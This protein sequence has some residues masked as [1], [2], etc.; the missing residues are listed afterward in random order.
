MSAHLFETRVTDWRQFFYLAT[1]LHLALTPCAVAEDAAPMR[2][3]VTEIGRYDANQFT[4]GN[5]A[6]LQHVG[7]MPDGRRAFGQLHERLPDGMYSKLMPV[8]IWD[9]MTGEEQARLVDPGVEL[10]SLV[11][12]PS[13]RYLAGAANGTGVIVWDLEV[14][15]VA[16]TRLV[17]G[18]YVGFIDDDTLVVA[19]GQ[20]KVMRWKSTEAPVPIPGTEKL[21]SFD[22]SRDGS[23][24]IATVGQFND[25]VRVLVDTRAAKRLREFADWGNARNVQISPDGRTAL[26]TF[27]N[28][29]LAWYDLETGKQRQLVRHPGFSNE[30]GAEFVYFDPSSR[31]ALWCFQAST[32]IVSVIELESGKERLRIV[33]PVPGAEYN[34]A[35]SAD[36][37]LLLFGSQKLSLF[38]MSYE[39]AE[40]LGIVGGGETFPD[41]DWVDAL[42]RKEQESL[43]PGKSLSVSASVLSANIAQEHE[44]D[45]ARL[46]WSELKDGETPVIARI[47]LLT[48]K[49]TDEA[50]PAS[51]PRFGLTIENAISSMTID[52]EAIGAGS[53]STLSLPNMPLLLRELVRQSLLVAARDE[54]GLSTWDES[55]DGTDSNSARS[56]EIAVL[57]NVTA[58]EI[59]VRLVDLSRDGSQLWEER[60]ATPSDAADQETNPA[61]TAERAVMRYRVLLERAERW[62]RLV[63][64]KVLRA[65]GY[66][67]NQRPR[68]TAAKVPASAIT[69]VRS[70]ELTTTF[71]ALRELHSLAL[72]SSRSPAVSANL[73]HGYSNLGL[74][75]ESHWSAFHKSC[76]ARALLYAQR[77]IAG[78]PSD[79]RL[80]AARA[81]AWAL[82]GIHS[83]AL[84]DASR[85]R[86]AYEG[87]IGAAPPGWL[88]VIE[89]HCRWDRATLSA[90]AANDPHRR[91]AS[92]LLFQELDEPL[93][94]LAASRLG[95]EILRD[96][97]ACFRV[98][99]GLCNVRPL[100]VRRLAAEAGP[101]ALDGQLRA[102]LPEWSIAIDELKR[103][104][105]ANDET[106]VEVG[107]VIRLLRLRSEF[108]PGEPGWSAM[109]TMLSDLQF[110]QAL[111]YIEL[112]KNA[113]AAPIG[114][115][116]AAVRKEID[117]HPLMPVIAGELQ[118][119]GLSQS[120]VLPQGPG[121]AAL[122]MSPLLSKALAELSPAHRASLRTYYRQ[123]PSPVVS[124]GF[125]A[126]LDNSCDMITGDLLAFTRS[127][128]SGSEVD[129]MILRVSPRCPVAFARF[130]RRADASAIA[131][132]LRDLETSHSESAVMQRA[133]ADRYALAKDAESQER[134]LRRYV[135]LSQE[136]IA[137]Q[138]LAG[139][140][141]KQGQLEQWRQTLDEFLKTEEYGLEHTYA[142]AE[143]ANHLM[144]QG[145]F[146]QAL[147]FVERALE[148]YAEIGMVAAIRCYSGLDRW[149]DAA[150]W[151]ER[152]VE[153]YQGCERDYFLWC[154]KYGRRP[155]REIY[156]ALRPA[157]LKAR[158]DQEPEM[159]F[160]SALQC[161]AGGDDEEGLQFF[162]DAV[163][164]LEDPHFVAYNGFHAAVLADRL[165]Q[166]ETRIEMLERISRIDAVSEAP[167][168]QAASA[169]IQWLADGAKPDGIEQAIESALQGAPPR[170]QC[171]VRFFTGAIL[172]QHGHQNLANGLFHRAAGVKTDDGSLFRNS[173]LAEAELYRQNIKP[174]SPATETG[175]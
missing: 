66:P 138:D 162:S 166:P 155:P 44:N 167:Y 74:M 80:Q 12:S 62:S 11:V 25:N 69:G 148:S 70:F 122:P 65:A 123:R 23:L 38:H 96:N 106:P 5:F 102:V 137:F 68:T 112:H 21:L 14:G 50:A 101:P 98:L 134:C 169:L 126:G 124:R 55:L 154:Q 39:F 146:T 168:A 113:L 28:G 42:V 43:E 48:S 57:A 161:V 34:G 85:A 121:T 88:A 87:R 49:P 72:R 170:E 132:P 107:Q 56:H 175:P 53:I 140:Y 93:S 118:L 64:P 129:T 86:S 51:S 109:G 7:I 22:V 19:D 90:V 30:N 144:D 92:M 77:M 152:R 13:G 52:E 150:Q 83:E 127:V 117:G 1:A 6:V 58:E 10:G 27:A 47:A 103:L 45:A 15:K 31:F 99:D 24:A 8:V 61:V 46:R 120:V 76:H 139:F 97:P 94:S 145:D 3:E 133:L 172:Q 125:V 163:A 32:A 151:Y 75:T 108:H 131:A 142:R 104:V 37:S 164:R 156:D 9:A 40:E 160:L 67:D 4:G 63:F 73:V 71:S 78:A 79:A 91:L 81:Y 95:I 149:D 111:R 171:N 158:E 115:L 59:H 110:I 116:Q 33:A 173:E 26:A 105:P 174:K 84:A 136:Y 128:P 159:W 135:E 157:I 36:G 35:M 153:R 114:E 16:A 20:M 41:K 29:L 165:K 100:G 54:L 18:G 17:G 141:K 130:I 82:A 89:A 143:L 147:P 60:I 2:S 119:E